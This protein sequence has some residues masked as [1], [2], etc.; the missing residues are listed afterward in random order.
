MSR[1]GNHNYSRNSRYSYSGVQNT[2]V[3]YNSRKKKSKKPIIAVISILF[4]I[5]AAVAAFF[6][7]DGMSLILGNNNSDNSNNNINRFIDSNVTKHMSYGEDKYESKTSESEKYIINYPIINIEEIDKEIE[8]EVKY[9]EKCAEASSYKYTSVDYLTETADNKYLSIVFK[10]S[11]YDSDKNKTTGDV[12]TILFDLETKKKLE[13]E[14]VFNNNF[15]SFASDYVRTYFKNNTDTKKFTSE[16]SFQSATTADKMHFDKFSLNSKQ[17][18]LYLSQKELFGSG[19]KIYD[20]SISLSQLS[21]C[22]NISLKEAK[23]NNS[24]SSSIRDN[25]DPNKPMIALTF[26]DGPDE[27]NTEIILDVLKAN[28]ARATFFVVGYQA[29][30]YPDVLKAISDAGCQ[31]GNHTKDHDN[32]TDLSDKEI[33]E[34]ADSV[35]K[36]VKKATGKPTTALRP[37]YGAYNENVQSVLNKTP[38]IF[39]DVDTEDWVDKNTN[40]TIKAVMSQ[41]ADGK[42]VLMHDIHDSTAE[43]AKTFI[44]RLVAEGYQLVT[45]EELL[46]YKGINVKG[47]ETYPW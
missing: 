10:A 39:W 33:K 27:E 20:V 12:N 41:A 4:I 46:Y 44:P 47:G 42:I 31:I 6:I 32:L 11:E 16:D 29:E 23:E 24:K 34:A 22:L 15:Y 8:A 30:A 38:L 13:S 37:P 1:K 2:Y 3:S 14:D 18:T 45:V 35:D 9:L 25:I 7:M 26:D 43:A 40:K 19:D 28:N 36:I 21:D 5:S 17:C